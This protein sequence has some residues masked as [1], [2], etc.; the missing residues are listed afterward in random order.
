[1][2]GRPRPILLR[3]NLPLA[4]RPEHVEYAIDDL[5]KEAGGLSLVP[6]LFSSPRRGATS[7][8]RSS[9]MR[10][11]VGNSLT[12]S[13]GMKSTPTAYR[14]KPAWPPSLF[15]G[16]LLSDWVPNR[17]SADLRRDPVRLD[18]PFGGGTWICKRKGVI[19]PFE[20]T[21]TTKHRT[22]SSWC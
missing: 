20:P 12:T 6:G 3:E 9:G 7:A 16:R 15:L 18:C 2:G 14:I 5:L 1:M 19:D 21:N 13:I 10:L 17:A 22:S 8:H 11:I 4:P